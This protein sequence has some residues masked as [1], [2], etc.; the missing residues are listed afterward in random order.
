M[1]IGIKPSQ[2]I[3]SCRNE[4]W[5]QYLHKWC[6]CV[7]YACVTNWYCVE[8]KYVHMICLSGASCSVARAQSVTWSVARHLCTSTET[9]IPLKSYVLATYASIITKSGRCVPGSE[10][11]GR[12]RCF[13]EAFQSLCTVYL[14]G[15]LS[16]SA[17]DLVHLLCISI[18]YILSLF[19]L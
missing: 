13:L 11:C 10:V 14:R 17:I 15:R 5:N 2:N 6:F 16:F 8:M 4:I 12:D 7:N 3:L 19:L 18:L 9:L 1:I